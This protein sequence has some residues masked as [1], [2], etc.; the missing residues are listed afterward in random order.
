[1]KIDLPLP[2]TSYFSELNFQNYKPKVDA[3]LL[4]AFQMLFPES[5]CEE[6]LKE[7]VKAVRS[8]LEKGNIIDEARGAVKV[9]SSLASGHF[10]LSLQRDQK[11]NVSLLQ[12]LSLK[13]P[14]ELLDWGRVSL[15]AAGATTRWFHAF[16]NGRKGPSPRNQRP[17]YRENKKVKS[18]P[19]S[20]PNPRHLVA[21]TLLLASRIAGLREASQSARI[22]LETIGLDSLHI[23]ESQ[24]I[25]RDSTFTQMVKN[26]YEL[27]PSVLIVA[28]HWDNPLMPLA[29]FKCPAANEMLGFLGKSDC[30]D[31][32]F[33]N[34]KRRH[35]G[36]LIAPVVQTIWVGKNK[37]REYELQAVEIK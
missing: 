35:F 15:S 6:D 14:F 20:Y 9:L 31:D 12:H 19:V 10:R 7:T 8:T 18:Q 25:D 23:L 29:A 28:G 34:L 11:W 36:S 1:M 3:A 33:K 27:D 30:G 4:S 37:A 13:E 16:I 21:L 17:P 26:S 5:F 2:A 32:D 24:I 22:V